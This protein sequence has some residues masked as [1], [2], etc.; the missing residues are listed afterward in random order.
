M[1]F[2]L[3]E[4]LIVVLAL[5]IGIILLFRRFKL[6]GVLGFIIAGMIAGPHG[7]GWVAA[8]EEV[9][10]LAEM[11]VIFLLFVIG[12]EFS[13]KKLASIGVTVF[14]GGTLQALLT[15]LFVTGVGRLLRAIPSELPCSRAS[16]SRSAPP[17]SCYGSFK[18]RVAWIP[19]S[20]VPAPPS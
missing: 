2:E 9:E 18:R 5:A 1:H 13:L 16:S 8:V 12:M 15:T 19:P 14:V 11:G 4:E 7:L 17:P 10:V 20:G 6:P 3:F